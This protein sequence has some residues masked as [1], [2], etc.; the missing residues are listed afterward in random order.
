LEFSGDGDPTGDGDD[1]GS[2]VTKV[3][4][5]DGVTPDDDE[6]EPE[7]VPEPEPDPEP[8]PLVVDGDCESMGAAGAT[9]EVVYVL[10]LAEKVMKVSISGCEFPV[11][12]SPE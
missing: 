10:P 2:K 7:P 5:G 3:V 12:L 4:D 6:P 1:V 9:A 11:R 8:V